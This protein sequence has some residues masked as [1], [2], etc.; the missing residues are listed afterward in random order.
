MRESTVACS[1]VR[2]LQALAL[3]MRHEHVL[4]CLWVLGVKRSLSL[5]RQPISLSLSQPLSSPIV[6]PGHP[7]PSPLCLLLPKQPRHKWPRPTSQRH[8]LACNWRTPERATVHT[9]T[10]AAPFQP[11]PATYGLPLVSPEVTSTFSTRY[12]IVP[13]LSLPLRLSSRADRAPPEHASR[14][15]RRGPALTH[16]PL[17][18][19]SPWA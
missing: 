14:W 16:S 5:S 19:F 13:L 10:V 12:T 15:P 2:A 1:R 11:P 7:R 8:A 4:L 3:F 18:L 9:R 17:P 6:C